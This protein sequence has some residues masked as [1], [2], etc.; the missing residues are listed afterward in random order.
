MITS[1]YRTIPCELLPP[2]PVSLKATGVYYASKGWEEF[3]CGT[4]RTHCGIFWCISGRAVIK[5]NQKK[6]HLTAGKFIYYYP[7]DTHHIIVDGEHFEY[8]WL[9]FDGPL[10]ADILKSFQIPDDCDLAG[11]PPKEI[12]LEA[13]KTLSEKTLD[14]LYQGSS[15]VYRLLTSM[16]TC[17]RTAETTDGHYLVTQFKKLVADE[18]ADKNLNLNIIAAKLKCHRTTL[19]R[20]IQKHIGFLPGQYLKH[21]RL[22]SAIELLQRSNYTAAEISEMCGFSTPEFFSRCFQQMIGEPPKR[23]RN[24]AKR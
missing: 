23:F 18:F 17:Q 24:R 22:L 6:H 12:F 7:Y 9:V 13:R 1:G 10:A 15:L 19:T 21:I 2:L 3:G 16:K 4:K 8:Y 14:A 11:E 5:I 20:V